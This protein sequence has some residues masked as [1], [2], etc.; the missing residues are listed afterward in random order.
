VWVWVL[1]RMTVLSPCMQWSAWPRWADSDTSWDEVKGLYGKV[2]TAGEPLGDYVE[3]AGMIFT[4]K[5]ERMTV[6]VDCTN[7]VSNYTWA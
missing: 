5:F 2:A 7:R 1:M 4:R 6:R 3:S